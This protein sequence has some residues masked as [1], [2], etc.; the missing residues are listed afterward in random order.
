MTNGSFY[1][2][3]AQGAAARAGVGLGPPAE[4][5]RP[6]PSVAAE[7]SSGGRALLDQAQG[8]LSIALTAIIVADI[9]IAVQALVGVFP[10]GWPLR[11]AM[12]VGVAMTLGTL[13]TRIWVDVIKAT[14]PAVSPPPPGGTEGNGSL[15]KSAGSRVSADPIPSLAA[16]TAQ[17]ADQSEGIL[18][19]HFGDH[20]DRA[21]TQFRRVVRCS[22]SHAPS[23]SHEMKSLRKL[24]G[25]TVVRLPGEDAQWNA[26]PRWTVASLEEDFVYQLVVLEGSKQDLV[27]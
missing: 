22:T 12:I 7:G 5:S 19:P 24:C 21:L 15:V 6:D 10:D 14:Q 26:E 9:G 8:P 27:S 11:S 23:C 3:V 13:V 4:T 17:I 25:S 20:P 18:R 1:A 16:A 2:T